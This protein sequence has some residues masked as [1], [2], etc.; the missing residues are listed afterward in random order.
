MYTREGKTFIVAELSANHGKDLNLA[1]DTISCAKD[2]GC[3]AV[4]IQTAT[5][6]MLTMNFR[7]KDFMLDNG[8]IWDGQSLF[9]LYKDV[10]LPW[11]WNKILFEHAKGIGI[12]I[13]SSPFG[14]DAVDLLEDL[15]NPIY[16]IA[17]FEI[18]DIP[19]IEYVAQT[20]KE[21][22]ISTGIA[23]EEDISLAL[24]ACKKYNNNNVCLL[25]CTS[26]YPAKLE[27]ANLATMA[28]MRRRFGVNIGLSD[29]SEG[30]ITALS[31]V[32]LG[33][34]VIEKHFILDK[35]IS[36]PDASFSMDPK[37]FKNMIKGIRQIEKTI[38]LVSYDVDDKSRKYARSL[39]IYED[40]TKGDVIS[41]HN[42]RSVRPS[43]GL[44]PKHFHDIL[45][46]HFAKTLQKGTPLQLDDIAD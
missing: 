11:E 9:E 4:K 21:I 3:D 7:T 14:L 12:T 42:I 8:T 40:V 43:N 20:G 15:G 36:S 19:L 17:S 38:G 32:A 30:I 39:F 26:Q 22:L 5:P 16:K 13:F 33:A 27:D 44:H 37:E 24:D 23:S 18:T 10:C 31:A 2:I 1:K 45:G 41:P 25:K 35:S 34:K 6:E 29:H 46:K 28:D